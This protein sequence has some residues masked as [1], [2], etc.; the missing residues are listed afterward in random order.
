MTDDMYLTLTDVAEALGC[1][2]SEVA[3]LITAGHLD[4]IQRRGWRVSHAA[5]AQFLNRSRR[6]AFELGLSTSSADDFALLR[7]SKDDGV[8]GG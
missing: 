7:P 1:D 6:D 3:S 5:L 8:N 4:A 2:V